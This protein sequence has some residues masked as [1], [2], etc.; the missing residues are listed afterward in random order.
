MTDCFV[1]LNSS[2]NEGGGIFC[3]W[4]SCLTLTNNLITD[5]STRVGGGVYC[6]DSSLYFT[7]CTLSR[8]SASNGGGIYCLE[9]NLTIVNSILWDDAHEELIVDS[10]TP[11]ITYS[12]IQGG[13]EGEG[14][15]DE[16]PMFTAPQEGDFHLL[17]DSPSIDSGDPFSRLDLDS[18]INDMGCYGGMGDLPEG[19]IGGSV[20]GKLSKSGSPYI[21]SENL[22]IESDSTLIVEKGVELLLHNHGGITVYGELLAEGAPD[23]SIT[24]KDIG[25]GT[26]AQGFV[27]TEEVEHLS[28][29]RSSTV[30]TDSRVRSIVAGLRQL[31][32]IASY[33][34]IRLTGTV[35]GSIASILPIRQFETAVSQEIQVLSAA[36]S[37]FTNPRR[38]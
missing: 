7:N 3:N 29:A 12:T 2:N 14:N 28:I 25:T 11:L 5:N 13:W 34:R 31:C 33:Q 24:I 6:E 4:F 9:S 36:G 27:S 38:I 23:D 32:R 35:E 8:N 20:S 16:D 26:L 15:I 1:Q 18:T 37:I 21:I 17:P 22:V 30:A 19:V 10:G